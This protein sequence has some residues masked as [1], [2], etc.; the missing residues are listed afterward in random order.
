MKNVWKENRKIVILWFL[1][2]LG[3]SILLYFLSENNIIN[4]IVQADAII[5][6]VFITYFYARQTQNLVE[7]EKKSLQEE[8]NKRYADFGEKRLKHFY[9]P[10][11]DNN[12]GLSMEYY[13][14]PNLE[15]SALRDF[16]RKIDAIFL[17]N[18]YMASKEATDI[19]TAITDDLDKVVRLHVKKELNEDFI[20]S[21]KHRLD[22]AD[23]VFYKD[24]EEIEGRIKKIYGYSEHE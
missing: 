8:K 5:T 6:L 1:I 24:I 19:F 12:A 20:K 14:Y 16:Q 13:N 7:Q 11:T 10:I 3:V 21:V 4:N 18:R 2:I 23:N 9:Y 17:E 15:I 22:K